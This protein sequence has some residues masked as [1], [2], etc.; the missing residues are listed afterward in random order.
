MIT[1][2]Q[3][4]MACDAQYNAIKAAGDAACGQAVAAYRA[5]GMC[6]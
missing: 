6:K 5:S 2:P 3:I 1:N 4:K